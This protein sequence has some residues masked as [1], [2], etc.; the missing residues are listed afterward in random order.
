M[1][2]SELKAYRQMGLDRLEQ[3]LIQL[4]EEASEA[5][6]FVDTSIRTLSGLPARPE[7]APPYQG[8]YGAGQTLTE[9]RDVAADRLEELLEEL[10][11]LDKLDEE[12]DRYIRVLSD[13]PERPANREPYVGLF[14]LRSSREP[15]PMEHHESDFSASQQYITSEQLLR[16]AGT[17][18]LKSRI[19]QLT[20]GVNA[21]FE[22][23]QIDTKL[24]MTH[25]LAQVMHESGG[26]RWLREIWGPTAA[27]RGYEGRRDLGNTQAGDGKRFMGRGLIQLTGR[28]NYQQ[29]SNAL[30]V[31]FV[32]N[33]EWVE[34]SPYAVLV[35][36]WFWNTRGLNALADQDNVR[37]ITRRINGG[38]NGLSDRERYLRRAKLALS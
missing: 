37:Q 7:G 22:R 17:S 34:R 11:Q 24:R 6:K 27:Q 20:P 35:A 13:L 12:I 5:D 19:E 10:T 21:T 32:A 36:G 28:N 1:E 25:F 9:Y 23:F 31:D 15:D 18:Q 29:F 14:V 38:Y 33:P 4:P 2:A 3:L 26:F 30:G 16:I 8:L